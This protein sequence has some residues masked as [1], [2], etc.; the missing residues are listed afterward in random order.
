M[1]ISTYDLIRHDPDTIFQKIIYMKTKKYDIGS[2]DNTRCRSSYYQKNMKNFTH[3][4]IADKKSKGV[5]M[6]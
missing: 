2:W 4:F 1:N 5:I 6:T 3:Y